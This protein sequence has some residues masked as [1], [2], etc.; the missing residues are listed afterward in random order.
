MSWIPDP[1]HPAIVHFAVALTLVAL[2]LELL[3]LHPKLRQLQ[4]GGLALF[5][6]AAASAVLAVVTGHAAHDEAVVPRAARRLL[7]THEEIGE[8]AMWWLLGVAALRV[9]LAVRRWYTAW[10]PWV[11]LLLAAV[12]GCLVGYNGWLGGKVVFDHGVGTAPV[13]RGSAS[14]TS[15]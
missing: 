10:R 14:S 13:Q 5:V 15:P 8:L 6:L 7:E 12:G 3:A 4:A 1:L 2:L 11:F 9:L